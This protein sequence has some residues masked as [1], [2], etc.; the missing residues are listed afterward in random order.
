MIVQDGKLDAR[1]K[2]GRR[3]RR[4][5]LLLEAKLADT[6]ML[7]RVSAAL[8]PAVMQFFSGNF[9]GVFRNVDAG[10]LS[11]V[12]AAPD[13]PLAR[14]LALDVTY[15]KVLDSSERQFVAKIDVA[16]GSKLANGEVRCRWKGMSDWQDATAEL[17][18]P[19]LQPSSAPVTPLRTIVELACG[20]ARLDIDVD[21][22]R[23]ANLKSTI[24]RWTNVTE[25]DAQSSRS[26]ARARALSLLAGK[27]LENDP[28]LRMLWEIADG[29]NDE[30]LGRRGDYLGLIGPSGQK[31]PCRLL[32]GDD[33]AKKQPLV[34][35]LHGAGGSENMFFDT[36][37]AGK[38]M[39]L[40]TKRG[41]HLVSPR[42]SGRFPAQLVESLRKDWNIDSSRIF[43]VGHSM[44]AAAASSGVDSGAIQP[45]AVALLGGGGAVTTASRW[46][47]L[48]VMIAVG[49]L[50]FG[51]TMA[52][53]TR[54]AAE[55]AGSRLTY[56]EYPGVEH[57]S[58]VQCSLDDVFTWLDKVSMHV[59]PA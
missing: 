11:L 46:K 37:G 40:C 18:L 27:A 19:S 29:Q 55:R 3:V 48:P 21:V 28:D 2:M 31:V 50:D 30:P 52:S 59:K 32:R 57:L 15:P 51:K 35:A 58:I 39:S 14:L 25:R 56:K 22:L 53:R 45:A 5:E 43:I 44:G 26:L 38:I 17:K 4:M 8:Q 12:N 41:W 23:V 49:E 34:I 13:G 20:S 36:Y 54:P 6:A 24:L 10:Y 7:R 9:Q 33:A 42:V 47:D 16:Y 1:Y